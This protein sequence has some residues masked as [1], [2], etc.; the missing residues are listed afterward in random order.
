M[1]IRNITIQSIEHNTSQTLKK[2]KN[3]H[4]INA[5][6]PL[7]SPPVTNDR[8]LGTYTS[9]TIAHS[10][11]QKSRRIIP[12]GQLATI[13][14]L[15]QSPHFRQRAPAHRLYANEY[16]CSRTR[17]S[18][19]VCTNQPREK[20]RERLRQRQQHRAYVYVRTYILAGL[21]A[22]ARNWG[23]GITLVLSL[24]PAYITYAS[25]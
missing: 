17:Y 12:S 8:T 1:K 10:L 24:S 19:F 21:D 9:H 22:H 15:L 4:N 23:E 5:Q 14:S 13:L 25:R 3:K 18:T 6:V 16:I 7:T 11:G 2:I 20:E